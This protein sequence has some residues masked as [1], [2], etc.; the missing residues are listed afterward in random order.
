MHFALF[1]LYVVTG[2]L[3]LEGASALFRSR[4]DPAQV[5][6]RLQAIAQRVAQLDSKA[7]SILRQGAGASFRLPTL[8]GVERLLYRAGGPMTPLRFVVL[9][10]ALAV[11]GFVIAFAFTHHIA[12]SL[13]GV[14][15]GLLPWLAVRRTAAAR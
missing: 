2:L 15:P 12:R 5:R 3:A 1:A 14:L 4:R 13:P 11:A 6:K 8:V 9:S 7:E 10:A